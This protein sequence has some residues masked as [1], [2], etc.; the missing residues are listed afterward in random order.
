MFWG[1][2]GP[3]ES[4]GTPHLGFGATPRIPQGGRLSNL[5]YNKNERPK[6]TCPH[7]LRKWL[8]L[9]HSFRYYLIVLCV[10]EV[11]MTFGSTPTPMGASPSH[12]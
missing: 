4:N 5:K 10:L 9:F 6:R 11:I 1:P 3:E 7:F 8:E 2:G 12:F